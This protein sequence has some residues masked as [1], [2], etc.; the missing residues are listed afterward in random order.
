MRTTIKQ[1]A[2]AA[3]VSVTTVSRVLNNEPYIRAETRLKVETAIA[4]LGFRPSTAARALAG[5]RSF[6]IALLYD[7]PSPYYIY[8]I[9]TGARACCAERGFRVVFQECDVTAPNL[10]EDIIGLLDEAHLDGVILSPPVSDSP[11]VLAELVRRK[12]PFV[13]IAPGGDL[14]ISPYVYM[15]DEAAAAEVTDH[16]AGLGHREIGFVIGHVDHVAS[17]RRLAGFRAALA[18]HGLAEQ[19]AWTVQ[20]NFNFDSGYHA[21][22]AMLAPAHRPTAVFASND[23]MAAGVLSAAHELGLSVPADVAIAGFD[24]TDL[25]RLVWP[26]LTTIRQ[27]SRALAY[28]AAQMLIDAAASDP[29]A[30]LGRR[31]EFE[32]I[33][34]GSTVATT[35][36]QLAE[37]SV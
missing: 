35:Q 12:M 30:P 36:Q 37:L 18:R 19:P 4:E 10:L 32:L 15:D 11:Q 17:E 28:A 5:H 34:R 33:A 8:N 20:G 22:L 2:S 16:L 24:D 6:Q 27:P 14:Q 7:N 31:L 1:V 29:E 9:Q 25:A 13:R 26:P 3:G 23:D 21:G